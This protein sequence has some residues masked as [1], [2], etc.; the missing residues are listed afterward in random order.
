M[1]DKPNS[2]ERTELLSLLSASATLAGLCITIVALMN[3]VNKANSLATV[4]DDIFAACAAA[5]LMCNYLIF[6]ALR[7][8]N[9]TLADVLTKTVDA[10]FLLALSG[11][12]LAAFIVI[13][14]IL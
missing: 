9:K 8:R 4:V 6:W 13:Y 2:W 11:M 1:P 3:A 14:T 12:T 10:L 5:F 7:S